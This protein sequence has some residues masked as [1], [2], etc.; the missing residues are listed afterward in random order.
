MNGQQINSG[1][2]LG[3]GPVNYR[4]EIEGANSKPGN[5]AAIETNKMYDHTEPYMRPPGR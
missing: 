2:V 4:F 5:G 3:I 1:D